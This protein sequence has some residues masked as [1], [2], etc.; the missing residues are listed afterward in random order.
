MGLSITYPSGWCKQDSDIIEYEQ[1]TTH[2]SD[3]TTAHFFSCPDSWT[4]AKCLVWVGDYCGSDGYTIITDQNRDS[5]VAFQSYGK[6]NT[7]TGNVP[8]REAVNNKWDIT[9]ACEHGERN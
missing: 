5:H 3:G 4:N 8:G 9:V 1:H 7:L 6:I 2:A